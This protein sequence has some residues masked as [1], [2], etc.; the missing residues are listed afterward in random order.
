MLFLNKRIVI[1]G[2]SKG[3]GRATSLLFAK[4]GACVTVVARSK[5]LLVSL[6]DEMNAISC[7][8]HFYYDC[9]LMNI[10]CKLLAKKIINQCGRIDIAVHVT[11]GSLDVRDPV[12][13]Y[14]EWERYIRYNA[15]IA[16]D[17]NSVLIPHMC[18]SGEGHIVHVSSISGML[19]RGNPLYA[20]A[21]AYLNAY[22]TATGRALAQQ[23]VIIN[24]VMPGAVAFNGNPWENNRI[25][26]PQKCDDFLRHHQAVGRFGTPQEI[27]EVISFLASEKA[28]FMQAA[29]V[30]VDGGNM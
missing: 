10:D 26:N 19:L 20:A 25:D 28:S 8:D 7:K 16:I 18:A 1:F 9:D 4:E 13:D 23:G 21:K 30:P 12:S 22:V 3:I 24:A 29:L 11:G 27:A 14:A 15:G 17:L 6:I 2:A 5:E